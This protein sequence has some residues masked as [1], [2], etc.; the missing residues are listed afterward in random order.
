MMQEYREK[1]ED[2]SDP[3]L[4]G[5]CGG[6]EYFEI[7]LR[8]VPA[9]VRFRRDFLRFDIRR[10]LRKILLARRDSSKIPDDVNYG[11]SWLLAQ[12]NSPYG[13]APVSG[14]FAKCVISSGR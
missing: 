5:N 14:G 13:M 2:R 4:N 8:S 3:L 7:Q 12:G 6:V 9:T 11:G 10:G 1:Y